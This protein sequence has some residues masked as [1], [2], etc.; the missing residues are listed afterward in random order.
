MA[1]DT[2]DFATLVRNQVTAI[3]AQA[4]SLV[5]F[6]IGSVLRALVEANAAIA[7]W[8]QGLVIKLLQASR[9]STAA[10]ADLDSWMADYGITRL[11]GQAA[12]G[13]VTLSRFSTGSQVIVPVG[14]TVQ[15]SDGE[16]TYAVIVDTTN[17]NWSAPLGA[18][19]MGALV[20]SINVPVQAQTTGAAGNAMAGTVSVIVGA[21]PGVDTVTNAAPFASGAN[22][23]TDDELR[24]RFVNYLA[25]L[26]KA[27]KAAIGVAVQSVQQG[28]TYTL[29]EN[30]DFA[31]NSL[32]GY[33]YVVVDDGSGAPSSGLL[34]NV[35]AA[36]DAVR[37][38]G[39]AFGVFGPSV[40]TANATISITTAA[41]Y[42][43]TTTANV[44]A[45][46]ITSFL[47]ALPL[48]QG[49]SYSRLIQVAYDASPGVTNVFGV[50]L[51][52][53]VLDL[54]VTSKQIIKAGTVTVG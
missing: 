20:S 14:A 41:A 16:T 25:S 46:A 10:D 44:V 29:V 17:V 8:L 6:T 54:S 27:T 11:P 36:I 4:V 21:L 15:T 53:A 13:T 35:Q 23:E 49:L 2:Q 28:L 37:P 7:L 32:L 34:A 40:V 19:V 51:N 48:G 18:Y 38:V 5:D 12:T 42:D 50:L 3:Q 9:A 43:H 47:N 45:A 52:G 33:F 26:S 1:L 39:S 31:G 22:A 30:Q 24:A